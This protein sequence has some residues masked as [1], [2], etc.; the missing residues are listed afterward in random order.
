MG[1]LPD[2]AVSQEVAT[3]SEGRRRDRG[4]N[5]RSHRRS[6]SDLQPPAGL[7]FSVHTI[8]VR[9]GVGFTAQHLVAGRV[10]GRFERRRQHRDRREEADVVASGLT[11]E[12]TSPTT[13]FAA[14][15]GTY[16]E[17]ASS[18]RTPTR[19]WPAVALA[20]SNAPET[21]S[22]D[23]EVSSSEG[24]RSHPN[25]TCFSSAPSP[26]RTESHTSRAT[27]AVPHQK[28]V[29]PHRRTNEEVWSMPIETTS[30]S[31]SKMK[32][33]VGTV[34]RAR[35]PDLAS[36]VNGNHPPQPESVKT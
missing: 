18:T 19:P 13:L 11:V 35:A 4:V 15:K 31:Q 8:V 3:N 16:A 14:R 22:Q 25:Q 29:G 20:P 1:L 12:A 9:T 5:C 30:P 6:Q 7:V 36:K 2:A 34:G 27:P 32:R 33:P 21:I 24:S 17:H 10:R 26:I 28:R 23:W